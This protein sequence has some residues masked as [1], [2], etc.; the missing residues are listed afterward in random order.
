[1]L[2]GNVLLVILYILCVVFSFLTK[3]IILARKQKRR[4]E[5]SKRND[6]GIW[7]ILILVALMIPAKVIY[8]KTPKVSMYTGEFV[9]E[10]RYSRSAMSF[11]STYEYTFQHNDELKKGFY[12]DLFSKKRGLP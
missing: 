3:R 5:R 10:R 2:F 6:L 1:M 4:N 11:P 12:L 9:K 8:M 7:L